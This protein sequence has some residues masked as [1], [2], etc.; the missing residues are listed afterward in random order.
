MFVA[1]NVGVGLEAL[2]FDEVRD[3][4]GDGGRDEARPSLVRCEG[5]DC[6]SACL[7]RRADQWWGGIRGGL[8]AV[9]LVP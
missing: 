9:S 3:G 4:P 1:G 5:K 7:P 2:D 8:E 6:V